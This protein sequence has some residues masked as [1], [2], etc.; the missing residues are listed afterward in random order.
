M[1]HKISSQQGIQYKD[2][3]IKHIRCRDELIFMEAATR[4][5]INKF[6][7]K[8]LSKRTRNSMHVCVCVCVMPQ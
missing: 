5:R 2:T 8:P 6:I 1:L 3:R 4:K 7:N